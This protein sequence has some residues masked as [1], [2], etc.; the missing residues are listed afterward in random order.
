MME[1]QAADG[2]PWIRSVVISE[3]GAAIRVERIE[4]SEAARRSLTIETLDGY[5]R[6]P[7]V[8]GR[9]RRKE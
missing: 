9:R 1:P 8:P 6:P 3:P 4:L 5:L 7:Y 2:T